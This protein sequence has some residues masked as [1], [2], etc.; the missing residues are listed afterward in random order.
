M[1]P[2]FSG[3]PNNALDYAHMTT[4]ELKRRAWD[5][6]NCD[7]ECLYKLKSAAMIK[8]ISNDF[9]DDAAEL[10]LF[11]QDKITMLEMRTHASVVLES[12]FTPDTDVSFIDQTLAELDAQFENLLDE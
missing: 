6:Q 11:L 12:I 10:V 8:A 3:S 2:E 1:S 5:S 4:A 7:L 9:A